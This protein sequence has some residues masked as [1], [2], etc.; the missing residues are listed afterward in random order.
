VLA[1]RLDVPVGQVPSYRQFCRLV[2]T[3]REEDG[4]SALASPPW[5]Y[6]IFAESYREQTA[7]QAIVAALCL[8]N[9]E[10]VSFIEAEDTEQGLRLSF[11]NLSALHAFVVEMAR[12]G[13][14]CDEMR[15]LAEFVLWTLGVRWV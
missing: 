8:A 9:P 15:R 3:F 13:K 1:R 7:I 14:G 11:A 10:F 2:W 6:T 5:M 4:S 12:C